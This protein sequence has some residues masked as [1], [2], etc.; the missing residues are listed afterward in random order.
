MNWILFCGLLMVVGYLIL[1]SSYR[2]AYES[3]DYTVIRS[4]GPFQIRDYPELTLAI[5]SMRKGSAGNDGSFGRLF[6]YISGSNS[7]KQKIAMTT[8]VLMD[9]GSTPTLTADSPGQMAFVMPRK[10]VSNGVPDPVNPEVQVRTRPAGQF[11]VVQFSGVNGQDKLAEQEG[12]LRNWL[13]NQGY[14]AADQIE[15]AGY[16]PPWI[17]GPL[18]LNEILIRLN[19]E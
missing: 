3:A 6:N 4:D 12:L 17:P 15:I 5:T 13:V 16:D 7:G 10:T 2:G 9:N 11:A 18:R 1:K 14:L 19:T 8:P